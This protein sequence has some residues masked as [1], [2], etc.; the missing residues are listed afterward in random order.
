MNKKRDEPSGQTGSLYVLFYSVMIFGLVGALVLIAA[1]PVASQV[2]PTLRPSPT[3]ETTATVVPGQSPTP[4][5]TAPP[6]ALPTRTFTPWPTSTGGATPT[7]TEEEEGEE[8]TDTPEPTGTPALVPVTP[9]YDVTDTPAPVTVVPVTVLPT[10]T[11]T[12][13]GT[14]TPTLTSTSTPTPTSTPTLTPTSTPTPTP[15]TPPDT[16]PPAPPRNL[17]AVPGGDVVMRWDPNTEGDLE[18]YKIY[19]RPD[20]SGSEYVKLANLGKR[21]TE[22]EDKDVASGEFY[23]YVVTAFDRAGNES[24]FSKEVKAPQ[25]L[26]GEYGKTLLPAGCT[27]LL[28]WAVIL[29]GLLI[30]TRLIN[31]KESKLTETLD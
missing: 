16:E 8:P 15:T 5:G 10:L 26:H 24:G 29:L 14:P 17:R 7:P 1:P 31:V 2:P 21:L 4:T 11:E 25:P 23:Y 3:P 9:I 6:F 18:G 27:S 12:S 30:M 22:Y 13:T 28:F 19:R 20:R